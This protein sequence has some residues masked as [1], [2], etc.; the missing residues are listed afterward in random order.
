M[1]PTPV[2][3]PIVTPPVIQLPPANGG[4]SSTP[5]TPGN[6]PSNPAALWTFDSGATHNNQ[7]DD[8]S[9]NGASAALV[10]VG[11]IPGRS[12]QAGHFDGVSSYAVVANSAQLQ[13]TGD[14]TLSAWIRTTDAR[15]QAIL[16]T[17]D[18]DRSEYNYLLRT[19]PAGTLSLLA[20]GNNVV[21]GYRLDAV[22]QRSVND[23]AWHH[24]AAVLK[25]GS[26]VTFYVD[27]AQSSTVNV[28][29]QV[30]VRPDPLT[31]GMALWKP[32]GGN[33]SGDI[34]QVRIYRRALTPAEVQALAQE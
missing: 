8:S 17:Y 31:I 21:G 19:N 23:G 7:L 24:V 2:V 13:L 11:A 18:P 27:G 12:G 26:G 20:G 29:L 34:D 32:Y 9:G 5:V 16:S 28:N 30:G 6:I 1:P 3:T 15:Y 22:D 4:T 14:L 25:L 10:N 33:F